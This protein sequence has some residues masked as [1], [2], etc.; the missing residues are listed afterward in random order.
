MLPDLKEFLMPPAGKHMMSQLRDAFKDANSTEKRVIVIGMDSFTEPAIYDYQEYNYYPITTIPELLLSQATDLE[1]VSS[2]GFDPLLPKD[3]RAENRR[4]N[5]ERIQQVALSR[6]GRSAN[7]L[8]QPYSRWPL[9]EESMAYR[10]LGEHS[11]D[12]SVIEL[13]AIHISK[14]PSISGVHEA[15]ERLDAFSEWR[16]ERNRLE[17][18]PVSRWK[19]FSKETRE[20][21]EEIEGDPSRYE[22]E[23]MLLEQI[24]LYGDVDQGWSDIV[25]EDDLKR[26]V[27]Q[28]V[29]LA[30][31]DPAAQTELLRQSRI[32]GALLYGP[33]GTGKTHLARVLAHEYGAVMINVSAAD[34]ESKWVG[35][36]EKTIKALFNLA[37][38]LS[39]SIIFID[40]A[41]AMFRKRQTKDTAWSRSF[42]N[43]FTTEGIPW[44]HI[45]RTFQDAMLY[46][47][48]LNLEYIWI[49]SMCIIQGDDE[50]WKSESTRMFEYYSNAYITLAS[51]F[52]TNCHGGFYS[53]KHVKSSRLYLLDVEFRGERYPV[54]AFRYIPQ[55]KDFNLHEMYD[56]KDY[57]NQFP[58]LKRSWIFQERLVS[59]RLLYFTQK[60]LIFDCY[61]SRRF[62]E[63][64][65]ASFAEH[66]QQYG[67]ALRKEYKSKPEDLWQDLVTAFSSLGITYPK[68][69]LPAVAAVAKQ[70]LSFQTPHS[71]GQEYLCGLRKTL[72][73]RSTIRGA[74]VVMGIITCEGGLH[75]PNHRHPEEIYSRLT[76]RESEFYG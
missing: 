15:F 56:S 42:L 72:P 23:S 14:R 5:I 22:W 48:R 1:M 44:G 36:S 6:L 16:E 70:L 65:E 74:V 4:I 26:A 58:L 46:A 75:S 25:L 19:D 13:L 38:K 24:V 21:I 3:F 33:P 52:S 40:E 28:I 10:K 9:E 37:A 29:N 12:A 2:L 60:Q 43:I 27:T 62:Q 8:L 50:D 32:N 71:P 17:G 47:R 18:E 41:D 67:A 68:D 35:E 31:A 76:R 69:K 61:V 51:T 30:N 20:A 64:D 63:T 55:G 66:K 73:A 54:Y 11:L 53:E 57:F 34:I 45:P 49:D 7:E 39:P 59:P